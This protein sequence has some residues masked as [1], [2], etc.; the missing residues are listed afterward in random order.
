VGGGGGAFAML[1]GV[2]PGEGLGGFDGGEE[3]TYD[4]NTDT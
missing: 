2:F 3:R 1:G 4:W